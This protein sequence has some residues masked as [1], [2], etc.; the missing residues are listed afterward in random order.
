M[1][2]KNFSYFDLKHYFTILFL[3][4]TSILFI[5]EAPNFIVG[6]ISS[7]YITLIVNTLYLGI[8]NNKILE[9]IKFQNLLIQR[10]GFTK[11]MQINMIKIFIRIVIYFLFILFFSI[12]FYG[13]KDMFRNICLIYF[14]IDVI[15]IFIEEIII[16]QQCVFGKNNFYLFTA[17][18]INLISHYLLIVP[19]LNN[20]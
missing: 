14:T 20:L 2:S 19:S 18:L 4:M 9:T 17:L 6:I 11:Y 13:I 15:L 1:I 3:L 16:L 8:V 7:N 12:L 5:Y 10:F